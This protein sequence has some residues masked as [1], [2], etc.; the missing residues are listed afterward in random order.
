MIV[1]SNVHIPKA[2]W[3]APIIKLSRILGNAIPVLQDH[4]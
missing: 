4:Q 2:T 1:A 3:H